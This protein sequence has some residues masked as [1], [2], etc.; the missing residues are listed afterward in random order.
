[1]LTS[2]SCATT[3]FLHHARHVFKVQLLLTHTFCLLIIA[4]YVF[5]K[6]CDAMNADD[7][8]LMAESDSSDLLPR[9]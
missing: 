5:L 6:N 3:L 7:T 1:M 2:F 4:T 9:F 8:T